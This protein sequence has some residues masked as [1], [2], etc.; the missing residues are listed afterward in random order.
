MNFYSDFFYCSPKGSCELF[1]VHWPSFCVTFHIL[2]IFNEI[3]MPNCQLK[4]G[5]AGMFKRSSKQNLHFIMIMQK[6]IS[7]GQ[8]LFLLGLNFKNLL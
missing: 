1:V 2:I 7:V 4:P 6:K 8:F 5:F 3:P